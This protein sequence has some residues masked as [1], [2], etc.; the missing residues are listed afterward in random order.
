MRAVHVHE[1]GQPFE[2]ALGASPDP[3]AG[4][5]EVLI[6]VCAAP[7]NY[8]DTLI[9]TGQYQFKPSLPFTPGKGPAGVVR[10]VGD[11]VN[12]FAVGDRVLAMAE[13]GGYA[14]M[15]VADQ[16]QCYRL[17]DQLSFVDAAA[18]AVAFDTAW[19]S[20]RERARINP[21]ETVLVLGA[22]GAVGNAAVQLAKIMGAAKVFAA[23]TSPE[24]FDG[25]AQFGADAM[26]DLSAGDPR[27]AIREQIY[28]ANDGQGVDIVIDPV[29]GD[30][31][32]GAIR[33]IAWR[34]RLVVVG[35]AGGRIPSLKMN[36]LLLKNIE[37]SGIQISNYRLKTPELLRQCYQE[38]FDYY[39]SGE[40]KA[41]PTTTMPLA[42]W[43]TALEMITERKATARLILVP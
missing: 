11:Q 9:V 23:V 24:K 35:F 20:L 39:V 25:L 8:V 40:I 31:F 42:E 30:A 38:I 14:E 26:I 27:D 1:L 17:P 12:D 7:V 3:I 43:R 32:D 34:G 22:T 16:Q 15:A 37:T 28:R 29:G 18:M 19:M 13:Y 33:A 2:A 36:Y 41:L 4:P 21:G 5:G 6:E 10:A